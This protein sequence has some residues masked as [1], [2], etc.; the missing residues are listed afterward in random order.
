VVVE[1]AAHPTRVW[2]ALTVPAEVARWDG[3]VPTAVPDDY[4]VV[5]QHARWRT[6]IGFL[7]LTLHD[8]VR[9][10][11]EERCL[12]ST[13]DVGIVHVEERYTLE[14]TAAGTRLTSDNEV[15]SRLPGL[16]RLALR[17]GASGVRSSM[18]RLVTHCETPA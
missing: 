17:L 7:G 15:R 2:R 9:V 1:I 18:A 8:R 11:D 16:G 4:P 5:G 14:A 6:K 10:V 13:I 12:A 3:V